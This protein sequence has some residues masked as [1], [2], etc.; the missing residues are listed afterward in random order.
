MK[1]SEKEVQG[2]LGDPSVDLLCHHGQLTVDRSVRRLVS[3]EVSH[4]LLKHKCQ[5]LLIAALR[6]GIIFCNITT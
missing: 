5:T 4:S 3:D 2:L 6:S 1:R